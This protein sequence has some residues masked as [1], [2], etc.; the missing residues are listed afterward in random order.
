[1]GD[2]TPHFSQSEF[3]DKRAGVSVDVPVRLLG[4]LE[5]LRGQVGRPIVIVSGYRTL[6]TNRAVGGAPASRHLVGDAVDIPPGIATVD[7]AEAAG[8]V[9][10]GSSGPW[11]IHVDVR[12][13]PPARWTY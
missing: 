11:A 7:Q 8:F 13:G 2:L 9:G 5:H 1:V 4:A 12:P 10:I 6:D 3:R